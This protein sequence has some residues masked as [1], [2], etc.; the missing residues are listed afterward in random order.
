MRI[1]QYQKWSLQAQQN[2]GSS[3]SLTVGYFGNHGIH[4]F[5]QDVNANAHNFGTYPS[6][7]C[8]S[9]PVAPCYDTRFGQ[10]QQFGAGAVS[11][12]NGMVVS[13]EKRVSGW[14]SG[15]LQINYTYGH[16]LDEVS[17]G[18]LGQF[19]FGSSLSPQDGRNLRGSYGAADY[20][21]RHSVNGNYVWEVPF[22][23]LLHGH[24][25]DALVQGWQ[26]SGTVIARSGLPYTV[27]D[28]GESGAL[29]NDNIFGPIYA[30][31]VGPLGS[32]GSCGEGAVV[33]SA[34]HPC[35]PPQMQQD[36]SPSPGAL[37]VQSGCETGFNTGN[38]P[39]PDGPC[40]GLSVTF[41]QGRNRF[42]GPGYVSTDLAIMKS[43]TIS[44]WEYGVFALGFQFFNLFNHPNFG[45]PDSSISDTTFGRIF[46]QEQPPTSVLGSGLN[47]NV[48]GRMIQVKAQL[49]F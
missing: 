40:S 25:P 23:E 44:H 35:L 13:F 24:S 34:P 3:T 6:V 4:E 8:G 38:L 15:L 47:A 42:R 1:A 12:Y 10:V 39:G 45:F 22:K 41:V 11:N 31:P 26:V 5:F 33:P 14:G 27:F 18:G 2:F 30:I 32:Q 43:T 36:G 20:D 7:P 9:P 19:A 29:L 37:F 49:R 28:Y 48:S 16:A 46:Y 17:N 21:V